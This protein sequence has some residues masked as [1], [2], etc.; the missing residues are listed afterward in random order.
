LRLLRFLPLFLLGLLVLG[1]TV[2][3]QQ[4]GWS[5]TTF[6]NDELWALVG[7][8]LLDDDLLGNLRNGAFNRGPERLTSLAQVPAY[9]L[10][11]GTADQLRAIHVMLALIYFAAAI[12]IYWL[13]RGL[14]LRPWQ[15]VLTAALALITPW[16]VFGGSLLTVTVS[17]PANMLFAWAV[18]RGAVRPSL[19][20]DV[21]MLAAAALNVL[22]RTGHAPLTVVALFAVVYAVWRRRPEGEAFG[23]GLLRLPGRLVR[24]HPLLVGVFALAAGAVAAIGTTTFVGSAYSMSGDITFPWQSIHEHTTAWFAQM[25]IASGFLPMIVGTAWMLKQVVRPSSME[26]GVFGVV[27]IGLFLVFSYSTGNS[28]SVLEERYVAVLGGLPAIAFA[29]ALFRREAW[30]L[31]TLLVGL[32][33]AR[34]VATWGVYAN[35]FPPDSYVGYQVAPGRLFFA[36]VVLKRMGVAVPGG[37]AHIVTITLLLIVALAVVAALLASGAGERRFP[38]LGRRRALLAT[39]VAVPVLALGAGNAA[40]ALDGYER[41]VVPKTTYESLAW[42]DEATKGEQAFMWS[43][44]SDRNREGRIYLGQL[45]LHFNNAV[46]CNLWLNDVE[47]L[48]GA[49]GEL[50][51]LPPRYLVRF[52]GYTPLGFESTVVARKSEFGPAEPMRVERLAGP[53]KAGFKVEGADADGLIRQNTTAVLRLFSVAKRPG[54]CVSLEVAAPEGATRTAR[55]RLPGGAVRRIAPRDRTVLR[56]PTRGRDA[57]DLRPRTGDVRLGEVAVVRCG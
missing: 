39:A 10:F 11:D 29:A 40:W 7:G 15:G 27:V 55:L 20:G 28:Y 34:A 22:S 37:D 4:L 43:D 57:I 53:P 25:T 21:L 46:C 38:A 50:P 26:T 45:A 33:A 8:R 35:E 24:T 51:G 2:W 12:P 47:D 44:F 1:A 13:A 52:T 17:W 36:E 54:R 42:V 31:G 3:S 18:W 16:A 48:V 56:L 32:V 6:T 19:L 49:D 14:G 23:R 41:G 9:K 5:L 30:P